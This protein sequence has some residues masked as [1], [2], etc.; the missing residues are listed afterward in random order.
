MCRSTD[1]RD[2]RTRVGAVVEARRHAAPHRHAARTPAPAHRDRCAQRGR[3]AVHARPRR[4]HARPRRHPR[5]LGAPRT[6]RCRCTGRR[7]RWRA[8]GGSFRTCST[9][10]SVPRPAR[11]SP[12][13]TRSR[14]RAGRRRPDRR[15]GR[16]S[17]RGAARR[18]ARVRLSHRGGGLRHG[19]E[20]ASRRGVRDAA[21]REGAGAE[22]ALPRSRIRRTSV[23]TR[24]SPRRAASAPRAPS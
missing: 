19:R 2:K 7:R 15:A 9:R 23:S 13:G 18:H 1:P 11:A 16:R 24:R 5:H 6:R 4:S 17:A 22:R 8:S 14:A 10:R 21:R 20:G 3:R 12:R